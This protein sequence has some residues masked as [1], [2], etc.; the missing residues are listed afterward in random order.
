MMTEKQRYWQAV[1]E[2]W[3]SSGL[4]QVEFCR[5]NQIKLQ[6]FYSYR[7][8]FKRRDGAPEAPSSGFIRLSEA[9]ESGCCSLDIQV[10]PVVLR[11]NEQTDVAFATQWVR[12]LLVTVSHDSSV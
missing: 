7:A 9:V 6:S 8:L 10:G 5:Q 12:Q 4:S 2:R 1:V 3:Q 11:V